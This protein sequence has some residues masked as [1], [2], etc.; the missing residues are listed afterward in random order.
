MIDNESID[1]VVFMSGSA[2][3]SF[4][5]F[6]RNSVLSAFKAVCIGDS[7]ATEAKRYG[8]ECITA[9]H[10]DIEGIVMAIYD[11]VPLNG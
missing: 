1:Y 10:A 6:H 8:M 7:T 9:H 5:Q 3:R 2:V 4:A 11:D